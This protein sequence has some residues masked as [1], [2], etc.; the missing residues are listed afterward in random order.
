MPRPATALEHEHHLRLLVLSWPKT[1]TTTHM[2]STSPGPVRVLL[3]EASDSALNGA[4]SETKNF[5]F[6]RV[7]GWDTMM[8][9]IIE[10]KRDAKEGK[11]KTVVVDPLNFFADKLMTECFQATRTKE[12]AED[13][14]RAHPE[15]SKRLN[16][17]V[18]LL[19]TIPAHVIVT[20][21]YMDVGGDEDA[22]KP[23]RGKG[24]VPLM[25]N[26]RSRSEIAAKFHDIVW[27]EKAW[28]E[29]PA[30]DQYNNRVLVVADEGVF[31]PGGRHLKGSTVLP[32]HIE[33]L[34]ERSSLVG[35][36]KP[37]PKPAAVAARPPGVAPKL[38]VK[39]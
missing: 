34:I 2:I 17:A 27:F 10:A 8:K 23:K 1:G 3:C 39:R 16:H 14:R 29:V 9:F 12:G 13:G 4:A 6:E 31:G 5:D 32:G 30:A 21:H 38:G 36:K 15:L 18:D 26:L 11:I 19:L 35:K 33:K 20:S 25:P 22:S 7:L 24:L 37:A 28:K